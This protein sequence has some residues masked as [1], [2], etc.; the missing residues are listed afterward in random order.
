MINL[1]LRLKMSDDVTLE[2]WVSLKL[3]EVTPAAGKRNAR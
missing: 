2:S 1:I 3:Q